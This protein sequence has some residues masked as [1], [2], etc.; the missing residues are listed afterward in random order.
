MEYIQEEHGDIL[1]VTIE[2]I[3][4]TI[5]DA[6]EFKEF[7]LR[8]IS[9]GWR[10]I[11]VDL[12]DCQFIDSTFLG[13]LVVSLKRVAE[14]GGDLRL[15]GVHDDVH[16]MFQLTRMHRVFELFKTRE[17]AILSFDRSSIRLDQ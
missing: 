5:K 6:I 3:S 1:L 7:L 8:D 13:A 11:I 4:A 10:K 2:S 12:S 9:A 14:L 16:S 17:E 15:L